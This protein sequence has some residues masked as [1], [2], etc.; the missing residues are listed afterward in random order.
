MKKILLTLLFAAGTAH[1][2]FYTGN[3]LLD[4]IRTNRTFATGYVAGVADGNPSQ[5]CIPPNSV[6]LGQVVDVV[7]LKLINHPDI[8]HMPAAVLVLAAI[9]VTWPCKKGNTL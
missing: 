5:Q 4:K 9:Q 7:E 6:T 8:R 3:E 1:A 2:Q